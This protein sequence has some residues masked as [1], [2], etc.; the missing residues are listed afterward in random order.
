MWVQVSFSSWQSDI[1]IPINSHE[2][3]GIIT[4]WSIKLRVPLEVSMDVRTLSRWGGYLALSR[5]SPQG[6]HTTHYLVRWKS[7]RHSSHCREI[8]HS[9]ESGRLIIHSTW[10]N[11]LSDPLTYLLL[12]ERFSW[13][14][15]GKLAYFFNRILGIRSLLEMI[16]RPWSFPRVPVLKLVF[17]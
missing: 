4:F 5:D 6:I 1:G 3:S 15:C 8:R 10:G 12:R 9:L 7:S 17:L 16:W 2:A 14:A 11:K 13:G